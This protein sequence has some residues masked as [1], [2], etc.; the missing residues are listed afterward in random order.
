MIVD[1]LSRFDPVTFGGG[2][3][4]VL[5]WVLPFI[6]VF[7]I[8]GLYYWVGGGVV[9]VYFDFF[10]GVIG[11]MVGGSRLGILGGSRLIVRRLFLFLLFVGVEGLVPY[12][13]NI[14]AN[15]GFVF[16]MGLCFWLGMLLSR[17]GWG[18][19]IGSLSTLVKD[20]ENRVLVVFF[21][22]MEKL[23]AM[24]RIVTLRVRFTVNMMVGQLVVIGWGSY[25]VYEYFRWSG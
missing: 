9:E 7:L 6:F 10:W 1:V 22:W 15:G 25:I 19:T 12:V 8:R 17:W 16:I 18:G 20:L 13:P 24:L 23:R 14:R 5:V 11:R 2:I 4:D 21:Y 3:M